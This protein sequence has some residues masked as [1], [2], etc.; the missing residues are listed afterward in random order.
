MPTYVKINDQVRGPFTDAEIRQ[1]LSAG[2]ISAQSP[3]WRVGM[4]EWTTV[5][6]FFPAQPPPLPPSVEEPP[7]PADFHGAMRS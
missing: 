4:A 2:E 1:K 6:A 7:S 5:V 3:A